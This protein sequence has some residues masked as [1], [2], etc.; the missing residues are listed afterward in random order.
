[1]EI[2]QWPKVWLLVVLGSIWTGEHKG[3]IIGDCGTLLEEKVLG[4]G[5]SSVKTLATW[6][7]GQGRRER[8]RMQR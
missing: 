6:E 3:H 1:M 4:W 5:R 8:W 7:E 2:N